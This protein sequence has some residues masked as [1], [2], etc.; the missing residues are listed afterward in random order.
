MLRAS[1]LPHPVASWALGVTRGPTL[2]AL[3][4]WA[5]PNSDHYEIAEAQFGSAKTVSEP[6]SS[7]YW[8]NSL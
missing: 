5:G 6:P 4:A 2:L 3:T 7:V 1:R 8:L